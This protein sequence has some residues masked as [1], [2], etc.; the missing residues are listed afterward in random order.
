MDRRGHALLKR[1]LAGPLHVERHWALRVPP[2]WGRAGWQV[3]DAHI[4]LLVIGGSGS[5]RVGNR[6]LALAPATALLVT[7]GQEVEFAARPGD[8]PRIV[9]WAFQATRSVPRRCLIRIDPLLVDPGLLRVAGSWLGARG[10]ASEAGDLWLRLLL[11][12]WHDRAR[13]GSTPDPRLEDLRRELDA[14]PLRRWRVD[15]MAAACGWSARWF[16][17]CFRA[18]YG[19]PPK[20]YLLRRRMDQ[21]LE[22]LADGLSVSATAA[23]L[24]YDDTALFARQ[25]RQVHGRPP[26]TF[27]ADPAPY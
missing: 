18:A 16:A 12:R 8:P 20:S 27:R 15:E 9:Q 11:Q 23:A 21:A 14:D 24:G 7:A 10:G 22:A 26:G 5:Y 13:T 6:R 4:L 3:L 1:L 2:W 17:R 19:L 25:F